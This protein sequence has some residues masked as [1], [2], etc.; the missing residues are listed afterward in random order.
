MARHFFPQI[1][2]NKPY[3]VTNNGIAMSKVITPYV[4]VHTLMEIRTRDLLF[5][6]LGTFAQNRQKFQ[7]CFKILQ[8]RMTA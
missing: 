6:M 3:S 5:Q 7:L 4:S 8:L 2:N 1:D